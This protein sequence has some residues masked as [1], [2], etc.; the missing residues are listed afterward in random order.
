MAHMTEAEWRAFLSAGTRTAKIA[1]TRA[2]GR[3]HVAPV[4]FLLDG[5][6]IVFNTGAD[7]VKGRTLARDGRVM[8]CVDDERPPFARVL[9]QG[10]ARLSDD[11]PEVRAW[12]T[13]IAARYMGEDRAEQYGA[14]NGV[15]GELLVRVK[16]EK[17][18][19]EQG[20]AD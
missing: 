3:P 17:V 18:G 11:L 16:I 14:R 4:W 20:V 10:T 9:V 2:D 5:D 12:A 13:R 15:P 7:T 6:E 8:L 19:A 1:T